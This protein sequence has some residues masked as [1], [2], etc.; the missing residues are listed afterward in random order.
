MVI[1]VRKEGEI[2]IDKSLSTEA[3]EFISKCL[4]YDPENRFTIDEFLNS[5]FLSS[6]L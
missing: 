6:G 3:K 4:G 5:K 1:D 2:V